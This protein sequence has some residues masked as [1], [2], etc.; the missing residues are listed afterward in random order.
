MNKVYII[1]TRIFEDKEKLQRAYDMLSPARKRKVEKLRFEKDRLLSIGAG[2]L[3]E[4]VKEEA[5]DQVRENLQ[6]KQLDEEKFGQI[7]LSE[8]G[9]PYFPNLPIHFSLSHSG[10]YA[11]CAISDN[12]IGIDIEQKE[13]CKKNIARAILTEY[14]KSFYDDTSEMLCSYWTAKEAVLKLFGTG[15]HKAATEVEVVLAAGQANING[16]SDTIYL[17]EYQ[18][19]DYQCTV[20]GYENL[21]PE[22]LT[23]I[24]I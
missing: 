20:A 11:V 16:L 8:Y 15:F 18:I 7:E 4:K 9:K 19:N 12:E 24:T 1:D 22:Q 21:F 3:L 2:F 13:R 14:E 6:E 10:I 17:K 5:I 23:W